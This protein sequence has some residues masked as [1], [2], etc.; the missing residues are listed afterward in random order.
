MFWNKHNLTWKQFQFCQEFLKCYNADTAYAIVY[1]IPKG[2]SRNGTNVLKSVHVL[3]YLRDRMAQTIEA[4]DVDYDFLL[5]HLKKDIL[6]NDPELRVP[7]AKTLQL[8]LKARDDIRTRVSELDKK[9][10][11]VSASSFTI[12]INELIEDPN[13]NTIERDDT[14]ETD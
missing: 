4:A 1:E 13:V 5:K 9:V 14:P 11:P 8:A 10:V 3:K 2:K 6:S 7:A 12:N